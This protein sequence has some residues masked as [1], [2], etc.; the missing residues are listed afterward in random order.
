MIDFLTTHSVE[1]LS[2]FL[3]LSEILGLTKFKGIINT[4]LHFFKS[5]KKK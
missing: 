1:I 5:F 4:L 3:A 2:I